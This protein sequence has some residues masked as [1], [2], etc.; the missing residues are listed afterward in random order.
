[1][2]ADAI[3]VERQIAKDVAFTY[4][5][6]VSAHYGI[7][8]AEALLMLSSVAESEAQLRSMEGQ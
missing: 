4:A 7:T 1:M 6:V 2:T 3:K 8:M 5:E